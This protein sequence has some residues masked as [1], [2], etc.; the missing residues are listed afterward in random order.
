MTRLIRIPAVFLA[1]TFL[2]FVVP[3]LAAADETAVFHPNVLCQLGGNHGAADTD[4]VPNDVA[5]L[6]EALT[7]IYPMLPADLRVHARKVTVVANHTFVPATKLY[8]GWGPEDDPEYRYPDRKLFPEGTIKVN[9][10]ERAMQ[11]LRFAHDEL[12]GIQNNE[13][14]RVWVLGFFVHEFTHD[15]QYMNRPVR[16]LNSGKPEEVCPE[17]LCDLGLVAETK[18]KIGYENAAFVRQLEFVSAQEIAALVRDYE[19]AVARHPEFFQKGAKYGLLGTDFGGYYMRGFG[20]IR[21]AGGIA[22]S[23]LVVYNGQYRVPELA[24]ELHALLQKGA[25]DPAAVQRLAAEW[26]TYM[27]QGNDTVKLLGV[28]SYIALVK[29]RFEADLAKA[30][31]AP[32]PDKK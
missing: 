25:P 20:A 31:A 16:D 19:A 21:K 24:L 5:L 32:A 30:A 14:G 8:M 15:T 27:D 12:G 17:G 28:G 23:A 26:S 2:L 18:L 22:G 7:V 3:R 11:F 29:Q 6:Q 9:V 13:G 4:A 1:L 10:S